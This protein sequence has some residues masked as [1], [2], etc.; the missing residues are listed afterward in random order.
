MYVTFC[1]S[2]RQLVFIWE[3]SDVCQ[4]FLQVYLS[5]ASLKKLKT[6]FIN[7]HKMTLLTQ[8]L[9]IS[10]RIWRRYLT[11]SSTTS[12]KMIEIISVPIICLQFNR[13][14][15]LTPTSFIPSR[16]SMMHTRFKMTRQE[17]KF[18]IANKHAQIVYRVKYNIIQKKPLCTI[19]HS[20]IL[21]IYSQTNKRHLFND[22]T[23][24]KLHTL[25]GLARGCM[26]IV[27]TL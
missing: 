3:F 10:R 9:Y 22:P 19:T 23:T 8:R 26:K 4:G 25:Y 14:N 13:Q 12:A 7:N 27:N 21:F 24:C 1:P 16:K 11:P 5:E 6:Y 17:C 20:L 18:C 15:V 2:L